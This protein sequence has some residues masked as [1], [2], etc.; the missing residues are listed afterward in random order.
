MAIIVQFR[1][2]PQK[3]VEFGEQFGGNTHTISVVLEIFAPGENMDTAI[4]FSSDIASQEYSNVGDSVPVQ[5]ERTRVL[6]SE[7]LSKVLIR[8]NKEYNLWVHPKHIQ[9][10]VDLTTD[11]GAL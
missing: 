9:L 5:I 3:P 6:L 11:L 4:P 1:V 10:I 8:R 7:E 2:R